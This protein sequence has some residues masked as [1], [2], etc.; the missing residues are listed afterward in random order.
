MVGE[1]KSDST[2]PSLHKF[3]VLDGLKVSYSLWVDLFTL[4]ARGYKVLHHIDGTDPPA[5]TDPLYDAW[6]EVDAIVLQWI[7][8]TMSDDLLPRVLKRDSTARQAWTRVEN[9]FLNNK[10][11]R[12]A[13][14]EHEFN[15]LK[16]GKFPNFDAYCQ[17]LKDLSVVLLDVGVAIN[18]Q[19]LVLQLVSGLPKEYDTVAA[20]INQT[21]PNFETARSMIELE[22]HR[23]DS[24]DEPAALVTH[25]APSADS[26]EE[27]PKT[28]QSR[29]NRHSGGKRGTNKGGGQRSQSKQATNSAMPTPMWGPIPAWPSQWTHPPCPYPTFPGWTQPW[30]PW[31]MT[32]PSAH[33]TSSRN[34]SSSTRQ[35][36]AGTGYGQAH[37]AATDKGSQATDI[38]QAFN[39]LT[40]QPYSP[41]Y[42]DT[43]ASSHLS[44]DAGMFNSP[45]NSSTIRSIYVGNGAS[46]PVYGS[47]HT[48]LNTPTRSLHLHNVLYTPKIIKNLI[49]VRQFTKDN[50]VSVEFD[51]CGFSV[52]DLA[53]GNLILRSNSDGDLYPVSAVSPAS[54]SESSPT[55]SPC[56]LFRCLALPSRTPGNF[57]F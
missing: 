51:P 19:R 40:L 47:G 53:N 2:K 30:Q 38:G 4:H 33:H 13:S 52:K 22:N 28:G 50:N 49:S 39:A 43:G 29:H 46:I 45:L 3:R 35:T 8:G 42:M 5:K 12:A 32:P 18:E 7:Y 44:A 31:P 55:R 6:S 21:L 20:Y 23:H 34:S 16:L 48:A 10:G 56:F 25:T 11:A 24:R 36:A 54:T 26:Q 15:N 17:R 1:D 57:Y 27:A 41:F 37:V 14:L 9:I